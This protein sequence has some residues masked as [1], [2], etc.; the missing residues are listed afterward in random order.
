MDLAFPVF[1]REKD[2][3]DIQRFE[4]LYE[5]QRQLERIDIENDEYEAW[6]TTGARLS[7]RAQQPVWL[8]VSRATDASPDELRSALQDYAGQQGIQLTAR[9]GTTF[10]ELFDQIDRLR[11][12]HKSTGKR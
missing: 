2:S 1:V 4:S 5:M 12:A 6:D 11:T 8:A 9:E 10:V 3:G 7:L